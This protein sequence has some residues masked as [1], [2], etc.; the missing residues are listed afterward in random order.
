MN[1]ILVCFLASAPVK[2]LTIS[3]SSHTLT[4]TI[5]FWTILKEMETEHKQS[6][7]FFKGVNLLANTTDP[8]VQSECLKDLSLPKY[9]QQKTTEPRT[10]RGQQVQVSSQLSACG[11]WTSHHPLVPKQERVGAADTTPGSWYWQ[12]AVQASSATAHY[13]QSTSVFRPHLKMLLATPLSD[14]HSASNWQILIYMRNSILST[15]YGILFNTFV[16]ELKDSRTNLGQAIQL[17]C[18]KPY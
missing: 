10:Q 14:F 15:Y 12:Q 8:S 13:S 3:I 18:T 9:F 1:S 11:F 4:L 6:H 2:Y 5:A 7:L 16:F 17:L